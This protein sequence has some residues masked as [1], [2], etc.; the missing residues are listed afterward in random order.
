MMKGVGADVQLN[1]VDAL[2]ISPLERTHITQNR[3]ALNFSNLLQGSGSVS[4]A[5]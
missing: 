4:G 3:D 2:L 5:S 1:A